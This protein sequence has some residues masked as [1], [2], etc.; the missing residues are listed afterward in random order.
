MSAVALSSA[1]T[2]DDPA[3]AGGA[4]TVVEATNVTGTVTIGGT[5]SDMS[6]LA[7]QAYVV[8]VVP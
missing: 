3:V 5:M 4:L 1:L 6:G 8:I 7:R 2:V